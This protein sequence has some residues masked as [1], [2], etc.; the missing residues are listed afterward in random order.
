MRLVGGDYRHD[1]MPEGPYD[2]ALLSAIIHQ[3]DP[4]ENEQLYAKIHEVL[5]PGG[6]LI[7]RDHVLEPD[8]T[9]PADGALFAVNMLVATEGGNCYTFEEIRGSLEAAGFGRVRLLQRDERMSGLVEAT[10]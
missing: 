5:A 6:R 3:N 9:A 1:R 8:R 7:V 10:K 2:L 4:R